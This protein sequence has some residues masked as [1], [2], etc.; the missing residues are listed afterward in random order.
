MSTQETRIDSL[1]I[2]TESFEALPIEIIWIIME[3]L[4]PSDWLSFMLSYRRASEYALNP[5]LVS[6]Y[7]S[8]C[9]GFYKTGETYKY[10]YHAFKHNMR[11]HG[12]FMSTA[13]H[14][15]HNIQNYSD[16]KLHGDC[17]TYYAGSGEFSYNYYIN[18]MKNGIS[19]LVYMRSGLPITIV[20]NYK[21]DFKRGL[22]I[23]ISGSK[24]SI[25]DHN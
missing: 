24:V 20:K 8:S 10:Y 1:P 19:I 2:A 4:L 17:I 12:S 25:R 23:Q 15:S 22:E 13:K 3:F 16:G 5:I 6:E 11:K 21:N 9:V 18:G 7:K 14:G